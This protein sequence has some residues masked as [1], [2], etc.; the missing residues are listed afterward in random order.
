VTLAVPF[1]AA[2]V[3]SA[4]TVWLARG[5]AHR[6]DWLDRPNSRS[7]HEVPIPRLGGIG[8]W[9]ATLV[10]TVVAALAG[11][12]WPLDD[13]YLWPVLLG[14]LIMA[15]TGLADDLLPRGLTPATKYSGQLAAALATIVAA[16]G[17]LPSAALSEIAGSTTG[18]LLVVVLVGSFQVLWLTAYANFANF[19]DGSDGLLAG[20]SII[21]L[22]SLAFL[23]SGNERGLAGLA[24]VAAA[25]T[26]GLLA[27]NRPPAGIF[28]GDSGSLFLG[29]LLAA[30]CLAWTVAGADALGITLP[31]LGR[32]W[33][34]KVGTA[35]ILMAPLWVDTVT[36]LLIRFLRHRRLI[37]A[38]RDHLYQRMLQ[39]GK[40]PVTVCV[41]YWTYAVA[42]GGAAILTT[43]NGLLGTISGLVLVVGGITAVV[44]SHRIGLA[45]EP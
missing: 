25:A 7:S 11:E 33:L 26:L 32:V 36:T 15:A 38:H 3:L 5:L 8:V 27:F 24:L 35:V 23:L 10:V 16:K 29:Y 37:E 17:F 28:M 22:A 30:L 45:V 44:G 21:G 6:R 13:T 34:H 20:V 1:V 18:A 31:G 4:L 9:L 2:L 19:M 40:S 42:C 43:T 14:G 39:A 12:S 41:A